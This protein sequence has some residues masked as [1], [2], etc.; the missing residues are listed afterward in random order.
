MSEIVARRLH[1]QRLIGRPV[2][3]AV[4]AVRWLGAV[5]SQDYIGAKWALA[6]RSTKTTDAE[7]DEPA[8]IEVATRTLQAPEMVTVP[9]GLFPLPE[10]QEVDEGNG[11]AG[12]GEA[13]ERNRSAMT[14]LSSAIPEPVFADAN[15]PASP[16]SAAGPT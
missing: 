3:S 7:L 9:D 12:N 4:D 2:A 13:S 10:P 11:E 5:Q 16:K 15:T 6:Q 1:A 8:Q 14:D